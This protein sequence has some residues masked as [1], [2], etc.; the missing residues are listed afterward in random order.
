MI[1][2]KEL[3]SPEVEC[4]KQKEKKISVNQSVILRDVHGGV[5]KQQ[6]A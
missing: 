4:V 3:P 2:F 1:I 5:A 6:K